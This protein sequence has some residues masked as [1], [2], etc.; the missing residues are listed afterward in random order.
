MASVSALDTAQ[1]KRPHVR[2]LA[3]LAA[4]SAWSQIRTPI[5][6]LTLAVLSLVTSQGIVVF[7]K[8]YVGDNCAQNGC[9][10]ATEL[11]HPPRH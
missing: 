10:A 1:W 9:A 11:R 2:L 7:W 3:R 8:H 4:Y 6:I 5:V